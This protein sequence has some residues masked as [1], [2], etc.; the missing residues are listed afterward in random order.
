MKRRVA[1]PQCVRIGS[2]VQQE[3]RRLDVPAYGPRRARQSSRL[4]MVSFTLAPLAMRSFI[5]ATSPFR[6]ANMIG[7]N[8]IREAALTSAPAAT[9]ASA[10]R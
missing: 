9:N 8:P 4:F 2:V 10:T 7:V 3:L 5:M 1:W 6:A